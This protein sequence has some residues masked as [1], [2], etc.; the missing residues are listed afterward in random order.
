MGKN[1]C[2]LYVSLAAIFCLSGSVAF[3]REQVSSPAPPT[4]RGID[5]AQSDERVKYMVEEHLRTDG[6]IDWEVLD[7]EVSQGHVMLYGEVETEDQK[8][9]A[10]LIASTVSGVRAINNRIIV[11]A[12][13]SNDHHLQKAVWSAL[14]DVDGLRQQTDTLRVRVSHGDI[15][16]AGWVKTKWQ[17]VASK[18]AA[19]SVSGIKK[20]I[21]AIQVG[22]LPFQT[23][24][25][26][27]YKKGL[28]LM[29]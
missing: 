5:Q 19:E 21:N 11:D 20:V 17:K 18:K 2:I 10:T 28:E 14:R 13:L 1:A 9:L 27:L 29:P 7:V 15:T 25:E 4:E 8:G 26:K 22:T 16:L 6:R 12:A 23:E 24:Q 3:A